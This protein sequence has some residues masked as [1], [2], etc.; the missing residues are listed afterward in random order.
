[1]SYIDAEMDRRLGALIQVG[2][3]S[4]LDEAN[5]LVQVDLGGPSTTWIPWA[6]VRAGGDRTWWAPEVGEQV[7][8]L[9]PSGELANA[10]VV[11]SL[12]QDQHPQPA[13]NK[14][15]H[16]TEYADGS[17]VEFNRASS[18]LT[19][20][21]GSG[22]VIIN[23]ASA[24]VHASDHIT[25]DTPQ[26]TCTGKLTV[27]GLLTYTAGMQGSGGSSGAAVISGSIVQTDGVVSSN[28]VI[29]DTHDHQT[30]VGPPV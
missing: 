1:M 18:T 17:S 11:G 7:I 23:C 16:R 27:E 24:E 22:Q 20:N 5:G 13:T 6:T 4:A 25:L 3:V 26:T 9:A 19:V 29:L 30:S 14:D 2:V 15:I 12:Y 21:V 28:G 10:F 8:V